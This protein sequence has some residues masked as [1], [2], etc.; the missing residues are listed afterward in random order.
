[1]VISDAIATRYGL[2]IGDKLILTDTANDMD[3]AFTVEDIVPYSVGLTVFMDIDSC[4]ELFGE[5]DDHYNVVMS[6]R[7]LDIEDGRLYSVTTKADVDK[8]SGVFVDLMAPLF[9][10]LMVMSAVI[11]CL[12]IYLM[13]SVMIDR[14]SFGISLVKIFGYRDSEVKK[15]YLDGNRTVIIIGA[16]ISIPIAKMITD[17]MFPVFVVNVACGVYLK[18]EWYY[19][20]LIFAA[21]VLIYSLVSFILTGKLKRLTPAEVLKNRE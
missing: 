6:D 14:A 1:M 21:I 18:Y 4:R 16:I 15:L 11:F 5:A 9:T 8:A 17:R 2:E 19:Y 12:V 3:Y 7:E 20:L 13:T 10:L